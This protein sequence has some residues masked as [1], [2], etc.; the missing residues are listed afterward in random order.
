MRATAY[1]MI[2]GVIAIQ[3]I[4]LQG[5]GGVSCAVEG[6]SL[7]QNSQLTR[8]PLTGIPLAFASTKVTGT[9]VVESTPS[10]LIFKMR[11]DYTFRLIG[12]TKPV[13]SLITLTL[14][15]DPDS[16]SDKDLEGKQGPD[17]KTP[18]KSWMETV[19]YHKDMWNDKDY[20]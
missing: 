20:S 6:L 11:C 10:T 15:P 1:T 7:L 14:D 8:S 12:A 4:R 5:N 18:L 9:E 16:R 13:N 19:K 17:G 2:R 3:D